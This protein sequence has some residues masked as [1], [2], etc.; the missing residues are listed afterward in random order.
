MRGPPGRPGLKGDA[1]QPGDAGPEG[2]PGE[3][4]RPFGGPS[5][6]RTSFSQKR[7][8]SAELNTDLVFTRSEAAGLRP[9]ESGST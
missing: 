7:V 8:T 5:L 2:Q 4:G 1:G 3:K 9:R 6:Q